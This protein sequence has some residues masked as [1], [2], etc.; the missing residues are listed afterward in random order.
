MTIRCPKCRASF[1]ADAET[2]AEVACPACGA[3]LRLK[4]KAEAGGGPCPACGQPVAAG[5]VICVHC[6]LDLKTGVLMATRAGEEGAPGAGD[7][8]DEEAPPSAPWRA[9]MLVAEYLPGLL[10]PLV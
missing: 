3:T 6:G 4:P 7:D 2:G 1:E 8:E 5:A 9:V 10:R